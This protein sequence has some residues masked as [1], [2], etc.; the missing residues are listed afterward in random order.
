MD[1][2][3]RFNAVAVFQVLGEQRLN[4]RSIELPKKSKN[5]AA[6][7]SVRETLGCR[8]D[9]CDPTKMDR[10]LL[11]VFD[12]FELG[13]IH[14]NTLPAQSRLAENDGVLAGGAHFLGVMQIYPE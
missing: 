7:D 5:N 2:A 4:R 6:Q 1:S 8:I 13:M 9:R 12:H 11:V 14:A 3:N 10:F